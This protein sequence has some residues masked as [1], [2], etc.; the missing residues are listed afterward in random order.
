MVSLREQLRKRS[1]RELGDLA[2]YWGLASSDT[3][4]AWDADSLVA[5]MAADTPVRTAFE[6]LSAP[7]RDLLRVLDSAAHRG[8]V[9]ASQLSRLIGMP[10]ARVAEL[11]STLEHRA[12]AFSEERD[13]PTA[14]PY[15]GPNWGGRRLPTTPTQVL[16][17]PLE[18]SPF[19]LE[20]IAEYAGS[21]WYAEVPS[22]LNRLETLPAGTLRPPEARYT[23]DLLRWAATVIVETDKPLTEAIERVWIVGE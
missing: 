5:Q 11:I 6:R 10:E 3:Q 13:L 12:L 7:E 2:R 1:G 21:S 9:A 14:N 23:A 4:V 15:W 18:T 17:L 22:P 19:L 8:W 20:V 16:S